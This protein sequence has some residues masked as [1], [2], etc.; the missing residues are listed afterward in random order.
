M[1]SQRFVR[2]LLDKQLTAKNFENIVVRLSKEIENFETIPD[3]P[4]ETH[5][6]TIELEFDF[7]LKSSRK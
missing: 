7:G 3:I 5:T 4:K 1:K 6:F 2:M